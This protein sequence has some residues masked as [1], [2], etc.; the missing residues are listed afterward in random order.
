LK[1]LKT[2]SI[3]VVVHAVVHNKI[4]IRYQQYSVDYR[5]LLNVIF[6]RRRPFVIRFALILSDRYL[7]VLSVCNVG[8]LWPNGWTDQDETWHAGRHRPWPHCV[9]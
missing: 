8:V 4:I 9:R 6:G 5:Y 3:R 2:H 1:V 7:S